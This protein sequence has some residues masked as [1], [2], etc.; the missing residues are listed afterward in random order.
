MNERGSE[1]DETA[2]PFHQQKEIIMRDAERANFK[3]DDTS[4][5]TASTSS[6]SD[7]YDDNHGFVENSEKDDLTNGLS[8][9]SS[10]RPKQRRRNNNPLA[11][12]KTRSQKT[13]EKYASNKQNDFNDLKSSK[14]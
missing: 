6:L 3:S 9:K 1:G 11:H 2:T 12:R 4:L 13:R 8:T 5:L 10:L 7:D 14:Q